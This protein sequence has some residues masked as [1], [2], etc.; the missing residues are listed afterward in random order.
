MRVF[1]TE[2]VKDAFFKPNVSTKNNSVISEKK[3]KV[4]AFIYKFLDSSFNEE[5][6]C[7]HN[8]DDIHVVMATNLLFNL[9]QPDIDQLKFSKNLRNL[10]Y[11]LLLSIYLMTTETLN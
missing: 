3:S 7:C 8:D 4:A 2:L 11:Q 1:A 10:V 6:N 5:T 9:K